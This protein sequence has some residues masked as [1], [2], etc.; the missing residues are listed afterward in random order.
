MSYL[1]QK[2]KQERIN[3]FLN[4]A[5]FI[6]ALFTVVVL[7]AP[8]R[9]FFSHFVDWQFQ[10][11]IAILLIFCY[12]VAVRYFFQAAVLLFFICINY[13]SL[14]SYSNIFFNV[15]GEGKENFSIVYQ[16]N[17]EQAGKLIAEADRQHAD[18][19]AVNPAGTLTDVIDDN[20]RLF[21]DDADLSKSFI[22]TN[23]PVIRSG[24]VRFTPGQTASYLIVSKYGREIMIINVDFS[25]MTAAEE[26]QVFKNMNEF[27]LEQNSPVIIVGNFG[28][29]S[30]KEV[31]SGFLSQSGME[32][33]N[34][35]IL[36]DGKSFFNPLVKPSIYLLG[37]KTLGIEQIS[38]LDRGDGK[39]Y[40]ILF[41]LRL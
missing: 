29:S 25:K 22:L 30:W 23:N 35:V 40:P 38:F 5:I 39:S 19:I 12:A 27:V 1:S 26:P 18:V 11:Y 37:Y 31:F 4:V 20:Y 3:S 28:V 17:T 7:A 10:Y 6:V 24:T 21:H 33:K 32:V 16:N 15:S 9:G 14:S 13:V 36:S 41:K 34:R 2:K 8:Q